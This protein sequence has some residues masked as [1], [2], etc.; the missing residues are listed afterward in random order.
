MNIID[1]SSPCVDFPDHVKTALSAFDGAILVLSSVVGVK[2]HS[3]IVD[4]QMVRNG[5]PRLI[6]INKVDEKGADPWDVIDQV[7]KLVFNYY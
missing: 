2:L 1:T 4:R 5:L 7:I 6:F 3:V